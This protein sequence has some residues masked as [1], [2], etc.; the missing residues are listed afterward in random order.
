MVER[1]HESFGSKLATGLSGAE[2]QLR[3]F[4]SCVLS[5]AGEPSRVQA[6]AAA[7]AHE[8]NVQGLAGAPPAL[9]SSYRVSEPVSTAQS[10]SALGMAMR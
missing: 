7:I 1:V 9:G 8:L 3:T 6:A 2:E 4:D 5:T 10:A